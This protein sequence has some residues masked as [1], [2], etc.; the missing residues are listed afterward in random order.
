MQVHNHYPEVNWFSFPILTSQM[1]LKVKRLSRAFKNLRYGDLIAVPV[2]CWKYLHF[3][4]HSKC[5]IPIF[6]YFYGRCKFSRISFHTSEGS[7]RVR[8]LKS[9]LFYVKIRCLPLRECILSLHVV[10][11]TPTPR[12]MSLPPPDESD[13]PSYSFLLFICG[14]QVYPDLDYISSVTR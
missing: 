11:G 14:G 8:F 5:H 10:K 4:K 1:N 13:V 12:N 2:V 7:G 9:S 6:L 3:L